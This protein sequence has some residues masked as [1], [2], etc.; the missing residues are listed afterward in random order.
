MKIKKKLFENFLD[1]LG[2]FAALVCAIHCAALPLFLTISAFG[3]LIWLEYSQLEW[4]I[5]AFSI[6]LVAG[7]LL[8]SFFKKHQKYQALWIAILG[9]A[10]I[11][12]SHIGY[13]ANDHWLTAFGGI[14]LA[15]A[16][17]LNWLYFHN[18]LRYAITSRQLLVLSFVVMALLTYKFTH[19]EAA[20][21][22]SRKEF[23]ELV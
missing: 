21:V 1:F 16:H 23:L 18:K 12:R 5:L 6:L 3:S 14:L 8:W 11:I 4:S 10:L 15:A 9:I 20:P 2:F 22:E 19:V 13:R 7:S 17:A